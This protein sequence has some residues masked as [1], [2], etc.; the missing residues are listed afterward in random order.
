[1]N[2]I[3]RQ[4][5]A[6]KPLWEFVDRSKQTGERRK[7]H[8]VCAACRSERS[9]ERYQQRRKEVLSYQKQYREKLKRE[10]IE[11]PVSSDQKES[12]GSVDD[13]YVRLAAEILR[14]EFSAYRRALEKY[15]GSPESIG[16]I[17][18]IEREI[19]T[20]YYAALTMNAIDLKRYCNDLRK[21]Y[22]IYG[23][24]EDWAG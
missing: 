19:L 4:C 2:R 10:R 23:G 5:G 11:T 8:R 21:K 12:C 22:G 16:R 17:R 20:Q 3:C 1:M 15:D 14:S 18:S 6:E 24:I 9:K 7:I 13:G